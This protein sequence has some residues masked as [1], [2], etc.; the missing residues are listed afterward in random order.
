MGPLEQA[1]GPRSSLESDLIGRREQDSV[2]SVSPPISPW[3][4]EWATVA[5]RVSRAGGVLFWELFV[6]V[7]NLSRTFEEEGRTGPPIDTVCTKVFNLLNP[8]FF[9][10]VLG[11][12]LEGWVS[13]F[14]ARPSRWPS[15]GVRPSAADKRPAG[16]DNLSEVQEAKV[17][18]GKEL[19]QVAVTSA[20]AR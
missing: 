7:A 13:V 16:W 10:V 12:I 11:L 3:R 5:L 19:A 17:S 18:L 1:Q 2:A 9:M 15:I 6:G 14:R 4:K 20:K 8:G